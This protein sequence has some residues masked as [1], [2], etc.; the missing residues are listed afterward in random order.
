VLSSH[1]ILTRWALSEKPLKKW[2][3][4]TIAYRRA[5]RKFDALHAVS[6]YEEEEQRAFGWRGPIAVIPNG[7]FLQE[8]DPFLKAGAFRGAHPELGEDPFVLFLSRLHKS[9]GID[10]VV[11]AFALAQRR[12]PNARLVIIGPDYGMEASIREQI[13]RYGIGDR[14]LITGPIFGRAKY[15][16]MVD[17]A[18]FCL[19]SRQEAFSVAILEA[20]TCCAPVVLSPECHIPEAAEAGAGVIVERTAAAN[21]PELVRLLSDPAARISMGAAGRMLVEERYTWE[22]IASSLVEVYSRL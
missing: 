17:C 18:C 4:M 12:V 10:I 1:G 19:P 15:E 7:V 20:M 9:K 21:A 11:D 16:A 13:A 5:I 6:R 8:I 2:I 14:V 3:A 22:K